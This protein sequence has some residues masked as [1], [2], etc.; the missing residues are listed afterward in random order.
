MIELSKCLLKKLIFF[1]C[2]LIISSNKLD[3]VVSQEPTSTKTTMR[4][5]DDQQNIE[6]KSKQHE[7]NPD[8][9]DLAIPDVFG[10]LVSLIEYDSNAN[11]DYPK[12]I[13]IEPKT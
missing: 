8:H 11:R 9:T 10:S 6:N 12:L 7:Q 13:E 5:H 4:Q 2:T 3:A 1:F